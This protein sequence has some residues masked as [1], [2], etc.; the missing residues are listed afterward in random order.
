MN[1]GRAAKE[2]LQHEIIGDAFDEVVAGLERD[3]FNAATP[4]DRE[5]I[6]QERQ[7]VVRVRQRLLQWSSDRDLEEANEH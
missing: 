4:E 6:Y 1:R 5:R 3:L 2:L 7:G